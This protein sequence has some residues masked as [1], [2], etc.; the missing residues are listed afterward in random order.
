MRVA[1]AGHAH[2]TPDPTGV[3]RRFGS[4]ENWKARFRAGRTVVGS[5]MMWGHFSRMS[6]AD[7]GALW[8]FLNS[9]EPVEH[10]VVKTVFTKEG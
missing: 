5:P 9:L 7:L 4:L 8:A 1:V 10:E 6:D 3:L 2:L